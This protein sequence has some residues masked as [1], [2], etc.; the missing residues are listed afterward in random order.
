M[1]S[2]LRSASKKLKN[3]NTNYMSEKNT[4]EQKI[5]EL[6]KLLSDKSKAN[7]NDAEIAKLRTD[8]NVLKENITSLENQLSHEKEVNGV[9][10]KQVDQAKQQC[11][12]YKSQIEMN[13]QTIE[14]LGLNI[15]ALQGNSSGVVEE[16]NTLKNTL[17]DQSKLIDNMKEENKRIVNEREELEEKVKTLTEE[18]TTAESQLT[19]VKKMLSKL[20]KESQAKEK[21]LLKYKD[22]SGLLGL[23]EDNDKLSISA[24]RLVNGMKW[25]LIDDLTNGKQAWLND[26]SIEQFINDH[27]DRILFFI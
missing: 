24:C 23:I 8:L 1:I 15:S 18:K 27:S 20:N 17:A 26:E 16:N 7:D 14:S 12:L 9:L 13:E 21:E 4:Y 11:A 2:K 10:L 22:T 3:E 5:I 6:N 25:Y 19:K